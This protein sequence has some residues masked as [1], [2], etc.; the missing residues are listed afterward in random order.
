MSTDEQTPCPLRCASRS[1][2]RYVLQRFTVRECGSCGFL[3][4][5]PPA[6]EA[7]MEEMYDAPAYLESAYFREQR[8]HPET[9]EGPEVAIYREGVALLE[10]AIGGPAH[11]LDVGCGAG[12]FLALARERGW[13]AEGLEISRTHAREVGARLGLPIHHGHVEQLDL[14]RH[15]DAITMWDVLEHVRDPIEALSAARR[16]LVPGGALLVF[17]IDCSSLFNQLG[18][19]LHRVGGRRA[20]GTLE[21]L[22]DEHHNWFFTDATLHRLVE[23]GGFRVDDERHYRAHLRRWLAAIDPPW[24][25]P[26]AEVVDYVSFGIGRAYRQLWILRP[27]VS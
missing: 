4:R 12:R 23:L 27:A 22:Y 1:R 10:H 18:H 19:L 21:L 6:S 13:K 14:G 11:L 15:F 26:A 7:A 9:S 2:T 3:Y 24:W 25:L 16:H 8:S 5:D 20:S 17:T